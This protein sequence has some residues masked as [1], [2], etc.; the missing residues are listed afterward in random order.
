M[1]ARTEL[2]PRFRNRLGHTRSAIRL[3]LSRGD[4]RAVFG[5]ITG[6]YLVA[7]LWAVQDLALRPGVDA[8]IVTV[9]DMLGTALRRIGPTSFERVAMIDTGVVRWLVSPGNVLVGLALAVL[10]G[11]SLSLTYLALV[12]PRS[13]GIGAGTGLLAAIPA[14]LG[15]TFCCGPV[16]AFAL[17]IQLTS[18]TI[19]AFAWLIP[20]AVA[21][22]VGTTMY[23]GGKIQVETAEPAES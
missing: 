3:A 19:T 11:I 15:G 6:G 14:L 12:Q 7:Y 17:G 18:L 1:T 10:V 4:S 2:L 8:G 23:L 13:C 5:M 9:D 20:V 16:I 22:L 21:M